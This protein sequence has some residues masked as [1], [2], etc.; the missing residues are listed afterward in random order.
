MARVLAVAAV[1]C[2]SSVAYADAAPTCTRSAFELVIDRSG[3]MTGQRMEAAK[4]GASAAVDKLGVND[5]V[6]VIA[7]DSSPTTIVPLS[8]LTNPGAVKAAIARIQ[9]QGGTEILTALDAANKALATQT[10]PG[11]RHVLLLTDG[12]SPAAGLQSLAQTMGSQHI[13]IT[14]VGLGTDIDENLLKDISSAASGRYFHVVDLTAVATVF[15]RD[16]ELTL[17]P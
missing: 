12:Q 14:T 13:T 2:A 16:V 3:S 6:G 9:P 17:R 10:S 8:P 15:T 1:F 5:C 7:F 11:K 4:A